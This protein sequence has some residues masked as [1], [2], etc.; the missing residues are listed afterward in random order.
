MRY[1]SL[2]ILLLGA[3]AACDSDPVAPEP[4]AFV[5]ASE[6]PAG[7]VSTPMDDVFDRIVPSLEEQPGANGLRVALEK[8]DDQAIDLILLRLDSD[9][10]NA[11]DVAAIRLALVAR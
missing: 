8:A 1:R 9:P 7:Q 6:V 4:P 11:P 3:L 5:R 2:S 10:S